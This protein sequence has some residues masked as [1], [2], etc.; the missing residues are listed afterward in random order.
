MPDA[1]NTS[2]Y[3]LV[4]PDAGDLPNSRTL[5]SAT[6]IALQDSG[7]GSLLTIAPVGN[8]ASMA[9]L[10]TTGYVTYNSGA[11]TFNPT[12]LTGSSSI[13]ITHGTGIGGNPVFSVTPST[14]VQ[15]INV[16]AESI[17]AAQRDT[18]NFIGQNGISVTGGDVAGAAQIIISGDGAADDTAHYILQIPDGSLVNSQA[19]SPLATGILKSTT[20]T[21]VISIAVAG[22][23]YQAASANLTSLASLTPTK[24]NLIGG[25]GGAYGSLTIGSPGQFLS[26][27]PAFATGLEW[28]TAAAIVPTTVTT[29]PIV[30]EYGIATASTSSIVW[31]NTGVNNICT[32][33]LTFPEPT[34]YANLT[35]F[36]SYFIKT[37]NDD[38]FPPGY[39]PLGQQV[40][41]II[42]TSLAV[43]DLNHTYCPIIAYAHQNGANFGIQF[44]VAA[45]NY[46]FQNGEKVALNR[47]LDPSNQVQLPTTF[48]YQG[49]GL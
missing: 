32:M 36:T 20:G 12:T 2:T 34:F 14:T 39:K 41:G 44:G 21:G 48:I 30:I 25:I 43:D 17:F 3:I 19:L 31:V 22:T 42:G 38:V 35:T 24:G 40:L 16:E 15:L 37:A 11:L 13:N 28:V 29:A 9:N 4:A 8:L 10:N 45:N 1:P 46:K 47:S 5:A 49:S 26:A 27:N 18:I 33:T 23:D 7:A 6:G